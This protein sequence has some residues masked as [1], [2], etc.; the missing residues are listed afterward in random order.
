MRQRALV[1][2]LDPISDHETRTIRD[3]LTEAEISLSDA[4]AVYISTGR[5][6]DEYGGERRRVV[7]DMERLGRMRDAGGRLAM[8]EFA[9]CPRC[10]QR[11]SSRQVPSDSCRLCLQYEPNTD[12]EEVKAADTYEMVQLETQIGEIDDQLSAFESQLEMISETI[13]KREELVSN[14]SNLIDDRSRNRIT[15]RLQAYADVMSALAVA[16]TQ[17]EQLEMVLRQWD[18]ASQLG[19]NAGALVAQ[20]DGLRRQIARVEEGMSS[21]RNKVIDELSREFERTVLTLGVPG[22]ETASI[23]DNTFLPLLNGERL[24]EYSSGGGAITATQVAYWTSLVRVSLLMQDSLYPAFLMIDSPRLALNTSGSIAAAIYQ[25]LANIVKEFP[26]KLQLII[27]D[28][29]IP[30]SY[31]R[32]FDELVFT[33]DNPTVSTV[34]HP[35]PARVKTISLEDADS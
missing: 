27:S 16:R 11:V 2:E 12:T 24:Q 7:Q 18:R 5:E 31:K 1:E 34:A 9:F 21:R 22:V 26:G 23:N 4:R 15:P 35:G 17:Q 13:R 10:M 33:Y 19:E 29:E 8:I 32:D 3:L 30:E 28:N 14:L 6:L 25:H 20:R